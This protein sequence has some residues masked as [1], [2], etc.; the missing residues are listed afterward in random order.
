V[1][2]QVNTFLLKSIPYNKAI[3]KNDVAICGNNAGLP[4]GMVITD[5]QHT[6]SIN[7]AYYLKINN[8]G[9][10]SIQ[11]VPGVLSVNIDDHVK[12]IQNQAF[13]DWLNNMDWQPYFNLDIGS[14][15]SVRAYSQPEVIQA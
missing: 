9:S 4:P 14:S 8:D 1:Y 10:Y 13:Y 3:P 11:F 5:K 12:F 2:R 7:P 6:M 15:E